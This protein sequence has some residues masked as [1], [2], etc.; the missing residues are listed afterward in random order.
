MEK[1]NNYAYVAVL[2][3]LFLGKL[4][5]LRKSALKKDFEQIQ[6]LA[7]RFNL[8]MEQHIE[9]NYLLFKASNT[10]LNSLI[11]ILKF[12]LDLRSIVAGSKHIFEFNILVFRVNINIKQIL[13][14]LRSAL[15]EIGLDNKIWLLEKNNSVIRYSIESSSVGKEIQ[16]VISVN[17]KDCEHNLLEK[18]REEILFYTDAKEALQQAIENKNIRII[19]ITGR[20]NIGKTMFLQQF[21]LLNQKKYIYISC[22]SIYQEPYYPFLSLVFYLYQDFRVYF[23]APYVKKLDDLF[24]QIHLTRMLSS[25]QLE[26]DI[27]TLLSDLVQ[28]I[29]IVFFFDNLDRWPLEALE[30]LQLL[31]REL[32]SIEA[33]FTIICG[34]T[35][36]FYPIGLDEIIH[37]SGGPNLEKEMPKEIKWVFN[38]K[39]KNWARPHWFSDKE[40]LLATL[41]G[42][43]VA[44]SRSQ[45]FHALLMEGLKS[46]ELMI[47]ALVQQYPYILNRNILVEIFHNSLIQNIVD[48]LLDYYL[49]FEVKDHSGVHLFCNLG[50]DVYPLLANIPKVFHQNIATYFELRLHETSVDL[51]TL[52]I[53]S[54]NNLVLYEM[55]DYKLYNLT[56]QKF[57]KT[58]K[59][60]VDVN[61]FH[62]YLS[63]TSLWSKI[64]SSNCS[65]ILDLKE[66][67]DSY[68]INNQ[69]IRF[70][71][72]LSTYYFLVQE[73]E[74]SLAINK[75]AIYYFNQSDKYKIYI[76]NIFY[77][78]ARIFISQSMFKEALEYI[79]IGLD[80]LYKKDISDLFYQFIYLKI[81]CLFFK[82]ELHYAIDIIEKYDFDKYL[83]QYG[84]L[85][86]YFE[87]NLIVIRIYFEI[88]QYHLAK[89]I[90]VKILKIAQ[91]YH[92][93]NFCISITCW[94]AR[95][96]FYNRNF[97]N[98]F[99]SLESIEDCEEKL[100]FISEGFYLKDEREKALRCA[101]MALKLSLKKMTERKISFYMN[102][103]NVYSLHEGQLLCCKGEKDPL[104]ISIQ[105]I[106]AYLHSLYGKP[107]IAEKIL[108]R[109]IQRPSNELSPFQHI[110]HYFYY[111]YLEKYSSDEGREEMLYLSYAISILQNESARILNSRIRHCYIYDNYWH[112]LL[113]MKGEEHNLIILGSSRNYNSQ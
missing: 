51:Y 111:S 57:F 95:V 2:E 98:G 68:Q 84:D 63:A 18:Y 27:S 49:L 97:Y 99:I 34:M 102:F 40:C 113:A 101:M 106:T 70:F 10:R 67:L 96:N 59:L 7:N 54:K 33:D 1:Y 88:G 24:E 69:N 60:L 5:N 8:D 81:L 52:Y 37:F 93:Q 17:Q 87:I 22:Y 90:L 13:S 38:A 83:N 56:K 91:F 82:K 42:Q 48:L 20:S 77:I 4:Y 108:Q 85:E 45:K 100:Y 58:V 39:K 46:E 43:R 78:Q 92:Y 21:C 9:V 103:D 3:I 66:E 64:Y 110:F 44:I 79:N 107:E 41:P 12:S 76:K 75:E 86:N 94:I 29:E 50:L 28:N 105:G 19:G 15:L 73:Y 16:E 53:L 104:L 11:N 55:I 61:I 47:L 89:D 72:P 35:G 26:F 36:V 65:N 25:K 23:S 80:S 112:N 14:R 30:F 71:L 109:I 32:V 62:D 31:C 6:E 74:K